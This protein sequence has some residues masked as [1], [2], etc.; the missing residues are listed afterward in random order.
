[1]AVTYYTPQHFIAKFEAINDVDCCTKTIARGGKNS[2][3]QFDCLGFCQDS[4][5]RYNRG[6]QLALLSM[7]KNPI[8]IWDGKDPNYQQPTPKQ[9]ILAALLVLI[10]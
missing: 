3:L 9:R 10:Q 8:Q 2:P 1:M 4:K 5:G 6:E 7:L